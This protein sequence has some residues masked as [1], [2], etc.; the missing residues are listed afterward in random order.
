MNHEERC[1]RMYDPK[2]MQR[3]E[4]F[5]NPIRR[6]GD[7]VEILVPYLG[8]VEIVRVSFRDMGKIVSTGKRVSLVTDKKSRSPR[9]YPTIYT[10]RGK[11]AK[12]VKAAIYGK[13]RANPING[14][15]L[16]LRRENMN[17]ITPKPARPKR[18]IMSP[19]RKSGYW[20][21]SPN[22]STWAVLSQCIN[23]DPS[24]SLQAIIRNVADTK[25]VT[26]EEASERLTELLENGDLR[27]VNP[28]T[29]SWERWEP[30]DWTN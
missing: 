28:D 27:R 17:V 2:T 29:R 24:Q 5:A 20:D 23:D 21:L 6:K 11:E 7:F 9:L 10:G 14:D 26:L 30:Y 13:Q 12:R 8:G 4:G 22:G 19:G 15:N 25:G 1:K 3:I 16:D 18:D